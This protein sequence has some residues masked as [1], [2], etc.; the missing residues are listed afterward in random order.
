M[1]SANLGYKQWVAGL[2]GYTM[3]M[4]NK[5]AK[6]VVEKGFYRFELIES[7]PCPQ[8]HGQGNLAPQTENLG[9]IG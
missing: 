1:E 2:K 3:K 8:C 7:R 5:Y 9:N 4:K 6:G